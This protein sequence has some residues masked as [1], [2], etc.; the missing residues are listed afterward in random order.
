MRRMVMTRGVESS[1]TGVS[2][3]ARTQRAHS[4]GAMLLGW[5]CFLL[6]AQYQS[7]DDATLSYLEDALHQFHT[8]KDVFL[9]GQASK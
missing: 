2:L 8:F 5:K 3:M 6:M 4:A 9:V 1:A 7:H